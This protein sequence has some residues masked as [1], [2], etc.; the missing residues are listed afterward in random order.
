VKGAVGVVQL[1]NPSWEY[2]FELQQRFIKEG[3]WLRPFND[4][5]YIMSAFTIS[6][7]ELTRLTDAVFKVLAAA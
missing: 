4:V 7:E 3:V 5:V 2:I 6:S 1:F